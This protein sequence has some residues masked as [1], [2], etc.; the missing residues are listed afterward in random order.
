MSEL[1]NTPGEPKAGQIWLHF[2]GGKYEIAGIARHSETNEFLVIYR[3]IGAHTYGNF[4]ARPL[5]MFM[6]KVE[7]EDMADKF[8]TVKVQRFTLLENKETQP[9]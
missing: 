9:N 6:D 7:I 8:L 2:R 5:S 3:S 1:E 4:T